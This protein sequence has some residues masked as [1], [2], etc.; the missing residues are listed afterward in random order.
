MPDTSTNA[1][2]E[3]NT[4]A[5]PAGTGQ[6]P[7]K[8]RKLTPSEKAE[9]ERTKEAKAAEKAEQKV[10]RDEEKRVKDEEKRLKAEERE[11][12]R[13]EKDLEEEVGKDEVVE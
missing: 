5:R 11:A 2:G 3:A 1:N 9:K 13:R 7:A 4:Q 12:K 6:P 10:R 8:R